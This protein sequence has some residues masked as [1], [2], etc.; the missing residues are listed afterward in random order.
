MPNRLMMHAV[1][2]SLLAVCAVMAGCERSPAGPTPP[3]G[4][5]SAPTSP[6]DPGAPIVT[7]VVPNA[8]ATTGGTLISIN[9]SGFGVGA[10][11]TLDGVESPTYPIESST[12]IRLPVQPHGAGPVD[13][14]VI[15]RYGLIGTLVAG[16]RYEDSTGTVSPG[17][18]PSIRSVFPSAG[19]TG[20]GTYVQ[21]S[22]T[23]FQAGV[24]VTVGDVVF[25]P[26]FVSDSMSILTLPH[27]AG[28]LDVV[29]TNPDGQSATLSGA[30]RFAEPESLDF[31]GHWEG[32]AGSHWDYVVLFTI[33]NNLVTSASCD[34]GAAHIFS[35]PPSTTRGEFAVPV[36]SGKFF[37]ASYGLGAINIPPCAAMQWEA[38]KR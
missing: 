29:V 26:T 12:V 22:G 13:V 9:G 3:P 24:T 35:E 11:V 6:P 19:I 5:S 10:R 28:T 8:G 23:G 30:Y 1:G 7:S 32:R 18:P 14:A 2:A 38:W 37:S 36:M 31:N 20:G 21:I 4:S 15:N 34:G 25:R 33:E 17:P 27:A 16:F